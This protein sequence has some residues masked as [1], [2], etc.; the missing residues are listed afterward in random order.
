MY[1][2]SVFRR[3]AAGLVLGLVVLLANSAQAA[4]WYVDTNGVNDASHGSGWG[5]SAYA[6]I[7]YALTNRTANQFNSGDVILVN[8]GVYTEANIPIFTNCTIRGQ[9]P[10]LTAVQQATS[11]GSGT[12]RV[13]T[14]SPTVTV[15]LANM[16][17]RNGNLNDGSTL[18]GGGA[19][20][21]GLS[22]KG[23]T[24]AFNLSIT[25]CMICS[26][27]MIASSSDY[28]GAIC[29]G[30]YTTSS[31]NFVG[32]GTVFIANCTIFSNQ[33]TNGRN[34][35]AISL[36]ANNF[37]ISNSTIAYNYET[38]APG[39]T[40][41][42]AITINGTTTGT[43]IQCTI[44]SN[45]WVDSN[46]NCPVQYGGGIYWGVLTNYPG[47]GG[48][49][50]NC[51]IVGNVAKNNGGGVYIGGVNAGTN[52]LIE[53]CIIAGNRVTTGGAGPDIYYDN[54]S[55]SGQPLAE[56]YNLIGNGTSNTAG[57]A[58]VKWATN[59]SGQ[60][61]TTSKNINNSYVGSNGVPITLNLGPL[62]N[63]NGPTMTMALLAGS[64]AIDN[65]IMSAYSGF[66]SSW[67]Q[68]GAYYER[69][70]GAN[71]DIGA[72]EYGA[73]PTN[74]S[75]NSTGWRDSSTGSGTVS[76]NATNTAPA[77]PMIAWFTNTA[78]GTTFAGTDNVD[79]GPD[80]SQLTLNWTP[81][82]PSGLS[83]HAA[84]T[85]SGA[86][87]VIWIAGTATPPAQDTTY[88][89]T[90]S[91]GSTA[92]VGGPNA[93][94]I[95]N[96]QS[97]PLYLKLTASQS[98]AGNL[99]YSSTNFYENL[100]WNDGSIA[101]TNIVT[102]AGDSWAALAS[103]GSDLIALHMATVSNVPSGLTAKLVV[104][105]TTQANFILANQATAHAASASIGN[106]I[107]VISNTA[108]ASALTPLTNVVAN[109]VTFFDPASLVTLNWSGASFSENAANDGTMAG[110]LTVTLVSN[111]FVSGVASYV[112]FVN[113]PANLVGQVTFVNAT[114][115]TIALTGTA[116]HNNVADNGNFQIQFQTNAFYN[117]ASS[118]SVVNSNQT[119]SLSF[120][121]PTIAWA[122]NATGFAELMPGN[123][124]AID[125]STYVTGTLTGDTFTA[126][127]G[128]SFT[129]VNLPGGLTMNVVTTS[130]TTVKITLGGN[131]TYHT[132]LNSI[133]N[134]GLTFQD[135]AF[136]Q[137]GAANVANYNPANWAVTFYNS[138]NT[139]Y[140]SQTGSDA[141]SG[142][143]TSHPF[144][145]ISNAI[146]KAAAYDTIHILPGA[147]TEQNGPGVGGTATSCGIQVSKSLLFV[148]EDSLTTHGI[149]IVQAAA[150]PGVATNRLF[151]LGAAPYV[152]FR[153]LTLRN[154]CDYAASG[155]Q[156]GGGAIC[157][158][159]QYTLIISN[160]YIY[161]CMSTNFAAG[162]SF[163]PVS[164]LSAKN[165]NLYIYDSII[166]S[167][168]CATYAGGLYVNAANGPSPSAYLYNSAIIGNVATGYAPGA[169]LGVSTALVQNCTFTGNSTPGTTAAGALY[170]VN[171]V[172]QTAG[173]LVQT[174]WTVRNCTIAGNSAPA[175]P[176]GGFGY[177]HG[178]LSQALFLVS[179]I[180]A[181]NTATS[182]GGAPDIKQ[183][184]PNYTY[185]QC[186]E[187]YNLIGDS[188][189]CALVIAGSNIFSVAGQ[190]LNAN[191]SYIGNSGAAVGT[192]NPQLSTLANNGGPTPTMALQGGSLAIDHGANPGNLLSD[193]RGSGY[194]RVV[195]SQA[196]IGAFEFG[197]GPPTGLII[198]IQ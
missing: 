177:S 7:T 116:V 142:L 113:L 91:L 2:T 43:I 181:Q 102:L 141:N 42:G 149:S 101:T 186:V 1:L 185:P 132:N 64:Q 16:T 62:Q 119:V 171:I 124:G 69:T 20:G 74:L 73:G 54:A 11:F 34:G 41:G 194:N 18:S 53:S 145:T 139:W 49:I 133:A 33:M 195:G 25:N 174:N 192:V 35:S 169:A 86:G 117:L 147:V 105:N 138:N 106:L 154:G 166:A 84:P 82:L 114:N 180:I 137:A 150:L 87:L 160:C 93:A 45:G 31:G 164:N 123:N 198:Y 85:N 130:P 23:P 38:N 44:Y 10:G 39:A 21:I 128:S 90:L 131:A 65:G 146:A 67:D 12:L 125:P 9:G 37:C 29:I 197:S 63:N 126:S 156:S 193:Q 165:A 134:L 187:S 46:G 88:T 167:N 26:N 158:K 136:T 168:T 189:N 103:G 184:N 182:I 148:G 13:F 110:S 121:N 61:V 72:Y 99:S 115:V 100:T 89:L 28:G 179:T 55:A 40:S 71:P 17:I 97:Y 15:A 83:V 79:W 27:R 172:G 52:F 140:V 48:A 59:S 60:A 5:S 152:S 70:Y 81:S 107:L 170:L 6:S 56:R 32:S 77:S 92:F 122:T 196:D 118:A 120:L 96:S 162:V 173:L 175:G 144:A 76:F 14:L 50:R 4:T 51:T 95:G 135:A 36:M 66:T 111:L 159:N 153:N 19:I 108:T 190:T 75:Y 143:D 157:A 176:C 30:A 129:P 68:R 58:W 151:N 57:T 109:A 8:T 112:Q 22:A 78:P 80:P 183:L 191:N 3:V 47:A 98:V 104:T 155:S 94:T 24:A 127:V 161:N 163:Y 188:T 178:V